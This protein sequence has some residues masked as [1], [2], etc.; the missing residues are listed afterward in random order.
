MSVDLDSNDTTIE[1]VTVLGVYQQEKIYMC[2][3]CKKGGIEVGDCPLGT[4]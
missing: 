2:S 3:N 4:L 1:S